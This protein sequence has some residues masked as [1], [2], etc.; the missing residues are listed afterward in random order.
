MSQSHT[1]WIS[2]NGILVVQ[3][4]LI[5]YLKERK[6]QPGVYNGRWILLTVEDCCMFIRREQVCTSCV[7]NAGGYWDSF[8]SSCSGCGLWVIPFWPY[9]QLSL[10]YQAWQAWCRNGSG[11]FVG[12]IEDA[13]VLFLTKGVVPFDSK[14][15]VW[16][17]WKSKYCVSFTYEC[18]LQESLI[19]AC[20][21]EF[22]GGKKGANAPPFGD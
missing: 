4:T 14:L 7:S 1:M 2:T 8:R 12:K 5:L 16:F 19:R 22:S 21:D 10:N 18:I 11:Y 20:S 15:L 17:P 6:I 9:S 3:V 13:S